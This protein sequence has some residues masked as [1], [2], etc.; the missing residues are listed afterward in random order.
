MK[1]DQ[2]AHI[3]R[4]AAVVAADNEVIV[5]GS[6]AIL[7]SYDENDLPEPAHASIEVD[8]FFDHDP[9][10]HKT[11]MVDGM[12]GEGSPFHEMNGYYAKAWM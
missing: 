6:Q 10:L 4:A 5:V 1:R 12:L 2:L 9:E 3:L 7:G 11:D 8:V